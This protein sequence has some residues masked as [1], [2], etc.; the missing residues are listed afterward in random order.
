VVW[1]FVGIGAFIALS[2]LVP[3]AIDRF[4]DD[5]WSQSSDD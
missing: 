4:W 3:L 1:V 5:G 2:F